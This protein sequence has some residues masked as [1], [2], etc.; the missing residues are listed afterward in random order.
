MAVKFTSHEMSL[1]VSIERRKAYQR[2]SSKEMVTV[3][4]L[5]SLVR[6]ADSTQVYL[7]ETK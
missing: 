7:V 3:F 4:T 1:R 2:T 6:E 5:E